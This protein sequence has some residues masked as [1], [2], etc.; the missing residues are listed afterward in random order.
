MVRLNPGWSTKLRIKLKANAAHGKFL[1]VALGALFAGMVFCL[2]PCIANAQ[3]GGPCRAG[4]INC[5]GRCASPASDPANCGACGRTCRPGQACSNG[6]CVGNPHPVLC[7]S[8]Q[9]DCNGNCV[10]PASDPANC[11]SCGRAC[12]P[13]Q[14]CSNGQCVGNPRLGL[15]KPGQINCNGQCFSPANDPA[16]CGSCG[17]KCGAGQSCVS[18]Q[19]VRGTAW[20]FNDHV[21][22]RTLFDDQE[23]DSEALVARSH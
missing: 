3:T 10:N 14:A 6:Q 16:N 7:K 1:R 9:I 4:Q 8:E 18:G 15:C 20:L 5:N 22:P 12:R 21:W 23:T 13:G 19:C 17:R 11:G 2:L